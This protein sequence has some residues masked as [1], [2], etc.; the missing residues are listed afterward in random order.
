MTRA[1]ALALL[2]VRARRSQSIK[3]NL[4]SDSIGPSIYDVCKLVGPLLV[5]I[6]HANTPDPNFSPSVPKCH[7]RMLPRNSG[8]CVWQE[9]GEIKHVLDLV[10]AG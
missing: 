4:R 8:V 3:W 5:C 2:A 1:S 7:K 6:G 10:M 9:S